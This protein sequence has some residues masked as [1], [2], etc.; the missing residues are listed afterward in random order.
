MKEPKTYEVHNAM[1]GVVQVVAEYANEDGA[2]GY[3]F[4]YFLEGLAQEKGVKMLS[5]DGV[6]PSLEN[7]ENGS[8]PLTVDLVLVTRKND[9]NPYVE[10]MKEFILSEDGQYIVRQTG[11]AALRTE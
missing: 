2:M 1:M 3:S 10:K 6:Y 4:R 5:V 7:V 8:Y 9:P 11:Y